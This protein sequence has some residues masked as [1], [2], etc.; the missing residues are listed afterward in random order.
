MRVFVRVVEHGSFT[1]AADALG[2]ARGSTTTAVARLEKQLGVRLLHRSTRRL[3]LTEEG[4]AYYTSCVRI[5]DDIAEAEDGLSATRMSPR[6]RLRV[7][8]PQSFVHLVFFPALTRFMQRYPE[9]ELEFLFSDRAVNLVE[10]GI[11]CAIRGLEISPDSDLVAKHLTTVRWMT[12][13][14][15]AYFAE[16]GTPTTVEDL[17]QHECIRFISQSTGRPRDWTFDSGGKS[18]AIVPGGRIR[19]TSFDAATH[20]A[21]AGGGIAQ[22]PDALGVGAVL[23]GKLQPILTDIVA[24]APGLVLVYP[25][26]RYLTAKV[27]AFKDFFSEVFPADGWWSTILQASALREAGLA[28]S[29]TTGTI[30]V[31]SMG[32]STNETSNAVPPA[33]VP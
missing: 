20:M 30:P 25:G 32:I 33:T 5:L 7:S 31:A 13:A 18:L 11:D 22:I 19:L 6:G 8:L 26:N 4:Q 15:P 23:D 29:V 12:C 3:S 27:R 24:L 10:E 1:R 9:L 28:M 21:I 17:K 14:S 2:I 16:H